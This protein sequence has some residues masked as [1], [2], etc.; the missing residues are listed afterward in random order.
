MTPKTEPRNYSRA[1][2]EY[3]GYSPTRR[4]NFVY[5]TMGDWLDFNRVI[6]IIP[7]KPLWYRVWGISN[8]QK[9]PRVLNLCH[10]GGCRSILLLEDGTLVK[11]TVMAA[12]LVVRSEGDVRRRGK[13]E[14]VAEAEPE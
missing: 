11:S 1:F 9:D 7:Y 4:T 6:G 5:L 8:P 3:K 10:G 2:G 14:E 12:T 13:K